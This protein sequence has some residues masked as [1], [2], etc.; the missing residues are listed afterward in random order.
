MFVYEGKYDISEHKKLSD[1]PCPEMYNNDHVFYKLKE[2]DLFGDL[3]NKL[4]IE[5]GTS[6]Q[7]W[8]QK[9]INKKSIVAIQAVEA[10]PFPGYDDLVITHDVLESIV[11]DVT[12]EYQY[13]RNALANVLGVYLILDTTTGNQYIGSAS[14]NN[15]LLERWTQYAK[16]PY[17]GGNTEF[18]KMFE[19]DNEAYKHFQFSILQIFSKKTAPQIVRDAEGLFK[20]KLGS[21]V[22]GLND[23]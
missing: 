19:R 17:H 6:T 22:F 18:K 21:K 11:N 8:Y 13:Y 5:W 12:G 9:A 1:F 10:K 15:G 2:T 16:Y 4:I 14:G 23:N 7:S 3:K 20:R